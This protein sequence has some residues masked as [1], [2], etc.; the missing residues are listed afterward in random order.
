MRFYLLSQQCL[1][2][3]TID[4]VFIGREK[5][6]LLAASTRAL[7]TAEAFGAVAFSTWLKINS[8]STFTDPEL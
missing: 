7:T 1:P 4:A 6:E 8:A 2:V 3:A 5:L